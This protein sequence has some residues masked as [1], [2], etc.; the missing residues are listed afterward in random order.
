M[1][2]KQPF[3]LCQCYMLFGSWILELFILKKSNLF[4]V[5]FVKYF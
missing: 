2:I 1:V 3:I 4:Y 5:I